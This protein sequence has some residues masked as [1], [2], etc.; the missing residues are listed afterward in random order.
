MV[1]ELGSNF[2]F[3]WYSGTIVSSGL[4]LVWPC[5]F[6]I[7]VARALNNFEVVYFATIAPFPF[8]GGMRQNFVL[9]VV[10]LYPKYRI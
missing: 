3:P 5:K 10:F 6:L 4:A 2:P 7:L 1:R 9:L 8:M